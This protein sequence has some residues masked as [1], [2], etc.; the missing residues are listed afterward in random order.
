MLSKNSLFEDDDDRFIQTISMV[1]SGEF[2][3]LEEA[4]SDSLDPMV[5]ELLLSLCETAK[6]INFLFLC[7]FWHEK[8]LVRSPILTTLSQISSRLYVVWGIVYSF[9][10]I[11]R[12]SFFWTK[13]VFS[14]TPY[15]LLWLRFDLYSFIKIITFGCVS[16]G[17]APTG[18]STSIAIYEGNNP[19]FLLPY[20]MTILPFSFP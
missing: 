18:I 13:V 4:D 20:N 12:Y 11:I 2:T 7:C 5:F 14:S 8:N 15:W 17:I 10:E 6:S 19:P 9:P 16:V 1:I 3:R